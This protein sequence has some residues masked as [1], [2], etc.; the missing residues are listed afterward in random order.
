L[1]NIPNQKQGTID[2][3]DFETS[4]IDENGEPITVRIAVEFC[5]NSGN[6]S[7]MFFGKTSEMITSGAWQT[8]EYTHL[9]HSR[10]EYNK[11]YAVK[12]CHM[13]LSVAIELLHHKDDGYILHVYPSPKHEIARQITTSFDVSPLVTPKLTPLTKGDKIVLDLFNRGKIAY[14]DNLTGSD[15]ESIIK[16]KGGL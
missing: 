6:N 1:R 7:R 9:K 2:T 15:F 5:E 10:S 3:Y 12:L 14:A 4:Q 13:G 16:E 11:L 8:R